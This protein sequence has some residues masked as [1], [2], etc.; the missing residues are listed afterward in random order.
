MSC[1]LGTP[2]PVWYLSP[3]VLTRGG[4]WGCRIDLEL[5][6]AFLK[7]MVYICFGELVRQGANFGSSREIMIYLASARNQSTANQISDQTHVQ[8]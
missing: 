7:R 1:G 5:G 4:A 6:V 2:Y 8:P 3:G